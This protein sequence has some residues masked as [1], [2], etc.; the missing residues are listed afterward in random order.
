[1]WIFPWFYSKSDFSVMQNI[2]VYCRF[3][4]LF[5]KLDAKDVL[6]FLHNRVHSDNS[7]CCSSGEGSTVA[8]HASPVC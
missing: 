3:H 7:L 5:R 4:Q 2:N 1:M 8:I 6:M